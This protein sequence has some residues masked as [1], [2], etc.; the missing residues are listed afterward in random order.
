MRVSLRVLVGLV[1]AIVFLRSLGAEMPGAALYIPEAKQPAGFPVPGKVGE[2]VIKS[3]P[4]YRAATVAQAGDGQNR[5][6][7]QLFEHIKQNKIAMT[8][9]VEMTFN[10]AGTDSMAFLYESREIGRLGTEGRVEVVDVPEMKVLSIGIRGNYTKQRFD[11]SCRK[12]F[13]WLE[14]S[15]EWKP[16][17]EPRYLAFNSPFVPGFA[18]YGEVQIPVESKSD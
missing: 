2:I 1:V 9:P 16:S 3:Y 7:G 15:E 10:E 11:A 4:A 5:L 18:R 17:G 14:D 8:A 6:F 12:L 13:A